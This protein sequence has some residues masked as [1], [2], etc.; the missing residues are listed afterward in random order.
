[1]TSVPGFI[2]IVSADGHEFVA[3]EK[4][5]DQCDVIK[6]MIA[7]EAME[8]GTTKT[9]HL[10]SDWCLV[11][12]KIFEKVLEYLYYR[13][14]HTDSPEPIPEF[15]IDDDLVLELLPVANFLG[16]NY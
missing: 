7:N 10:K 13:Y 2:K 1:M 3:D 16:L 4:M 11:T 6:R 9:I 12:G 14:K 8:E 15:H 5:L